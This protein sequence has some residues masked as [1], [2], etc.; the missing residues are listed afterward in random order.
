MVHLVAQGG[1]IRMRSRARSTDPSAA[2]AATSAGS[3]A[4]GWLRWAPE[5]LP[6]G[7]AAR[8]PPARSARQPTARGGQ[9]PAPDRDHGRRVREGDP[10]ATP[11]VGL[12]SGQAGADRA[13]DPPGGCGPKAVRIPAPTDEAAERLGPAADPKLSGSPAPTEAAGAPRASDGP[14]AVRIPAP[15]DEAAERLGPAAD[16]KLSGSPAPTEAAGAPRASYGPKAV[17]TA[18]DRRRGSR[19]GGVGCGPKAV[20]IPRARRRPAARLHGRPRS[21]RS[22]VRPPARQARPPRRCR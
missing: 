2:C 5:W 10:Q 4:A 8:R 7:P 11:S 19:A 21:G 16:P 18:R 17:R 15:T 14:K 12:A 22:V 9:E 20:R 13:A 3:R 6:S 1:R